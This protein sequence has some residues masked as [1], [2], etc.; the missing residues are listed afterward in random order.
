MRFI[1][2]SQLLCS[3]LRAITY[4]RT[5]YF[6]RTNRYSIGLTRVRSHLNP[7]THEVS[8][9]KVRAQMKELLEEGFQQRYDEMAVEVSQHFRDSRL[10]NE[11]L[12]IGMMLIGQNIDEVALPDGLD[13]ERQCGEVLKSVGFHV[14]T[15]P[16]SSDF[17]VDLLARKNGL[18]Y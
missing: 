16:I 14:D 15:T 12:M 11:A 4:R 5:T 13:F 6:K 2:S 3:V 8:W 1:F 10:A 9:N 7:V 17:G 18:T